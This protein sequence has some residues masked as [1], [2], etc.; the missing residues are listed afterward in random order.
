MTARKPR[1]KPTAS[2]PRPDF[3]KLEALWKARAEAGW[4]V[5]P[6]EAAAAER[7]LRDMKRQMQQQQPP[8]ARIIF[9]VKPS[10]QPRP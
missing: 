8:T 2:T 3:A 1:R 4:P 7:E 9:G 5:S 6:E 10:R